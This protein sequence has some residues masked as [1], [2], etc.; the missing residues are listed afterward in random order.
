MNTRIFNVAG[1]CIPGKHYMLEA[2]ARCHQLMELI[3]E[4]RFYPTNRHA[5]AA[6]REDAASV[7]T[8]IDTDR[9][10]DLDD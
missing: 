1:P 8:D 5:A 4:G 10:K 2:Q 7:E 6:F 3:D 9:K